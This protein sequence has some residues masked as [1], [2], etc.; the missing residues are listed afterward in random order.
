MGTGYKPSF[1]S[2]AASSAKC[3]SAAAASSMNFLLSCPS[4][5]IISWALDVLNPNEDEDEDE[6][7]DKIV[8]SGDDTLR[9]DDVGTAAYCCSSIA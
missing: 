6:V 2:F 5:S 8:G 1:G 9:C 7:G 3:L 4:N